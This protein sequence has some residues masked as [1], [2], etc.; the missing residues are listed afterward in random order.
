MKIITLIENN[1]DKNPNLICE[2]GFSAFIEDD[3][4]SLIFDTG[5]TGIF[6]ENI[7]KLNIDTKLIH[8]II[9]SHNHFDH[10]GGLKKYI[11]SFGNNFS[12]TVNKTFFSKR[13]GL[14]KQYSRLLSAPFS[15]KYLEK[16]NIKINFI[17]D[18]I[19]K[20][21]K[22][23]TAFTNFKSTNNFESPNLTYV[24]KENNKII[25][26]NMNDEVVLGLDTKKG[27]FLLCGCSHFGII[28]IIENVKLL[29]GKKVKGVI[30]GLHLSKVSEER[31]KKVIQYLQKENIEY[32]A[33]SHCTGEKIIELLK[34][35]KCNYIKN[36]TGT[37]LEL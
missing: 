30:G 26:D 6:I 13:F 24:K 25:F 19:H 16:N 27:F 28:N 17:N 2:F 7:K 4:F 29:S 1:V 37:I 34:N 5:Q 3:D 18:H 11:D 10:G 23:I 36:N 32:L 35:T 31:I 21:S 20:I 12:L 15:E 8:N 14:E 9:I 22:N 33:I